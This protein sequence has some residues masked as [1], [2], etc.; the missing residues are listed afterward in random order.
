MASDILLSLFEVA[1]LAVAYDK[2]NAKSEFERQFFGLGFIVT[3]IGV[4]IGNFT[5]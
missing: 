3:S 4:V 2:S 5:N 1:V